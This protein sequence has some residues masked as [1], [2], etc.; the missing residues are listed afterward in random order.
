MAKVVEAQNGPGVTN[1]PLGP[2]E[3]RG[4]L[5]T[6]KESSIRKNYCL[7]SLESERRIM[8]KQLFGGLALSLIFAATAARGATQGEALPETI[9]QRTITIRVHNYAQVKPSVLFTAT[10]AASDI[11]REAGVETVWVECYSGPTLQPDAACA[12]PATPLDLT[13]NLLPQSQAKYFHYR[14]EILGVALVPAGQNFGFY[15]YVFYFGAEAFA[16]HHKLNLSSF[17]G[18]V[19]VHELGHLLLGVNSHSNVGI[20]RACWNGQDLIAVEH[21]GFSFSLVEKKSFSKL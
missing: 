8:K 5:R 17:L 15:A 9:S 16:A 6:S 7:N 11:F 19:I 14:D 4:S 1:R 21:G 13:L 18:H 3:G 20:M 10:K 2:P 12:N